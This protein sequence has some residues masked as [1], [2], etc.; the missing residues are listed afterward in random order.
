MW[1]SNISNLEG[2]N[3]VTFIGG[4]LSIFNQD[5][6]TSLTGLNN[7]MHIGGNLVILNN[8]L[9]TSLT[10]IENLYSIAGSLHIGGSY[11]G[12]PFLTSLTG[13]DNVTS[14]GGDLYI[15]DNNSLSTCEV[16]SICNYLASP[17]GEITIEDNAT[18]CNNQW[19]VE[20]ACQT[21]SVQE[22]EPTSQ[23]SLHPNPFF[24]SVT[25]EYKSAYPCTTEINIYNQI[26][27]VIKEFIHQ[28][29][30]AGINKLIWQTEDIPS[31]IYFI[32]MQIGNE[33]ITK[34]IIRKN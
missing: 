26:G 9:L 21:I 5:F 24:N 18:G 25:I 11:G 13:L 22:L 15:I 3:V 1:G 29:S 6:L 27:Q 32:R 12:N 8:D 19:E 33:I 31:G 4:H 16:E 34:K 17:N 28:E 20:Q 23:L 2:L 10:G 7:V 14:I 30:R